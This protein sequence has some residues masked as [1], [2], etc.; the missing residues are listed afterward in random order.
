MYSLTVRAG[1]ERKQSP[2][3]SHS[4]ERDIDPASALNLNLTLN[5]GEVCEGDAILM[6]LIFRKGDWNTRPSCSTNHTALNDYSLSETIRNFLLK[7]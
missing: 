2:T 5:S 1:S 4:M 7:N 6:E 3:M